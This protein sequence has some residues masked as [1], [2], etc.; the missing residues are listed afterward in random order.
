[1]LGY[2]LRN[3][4]S[5]SIVV[6]SF[7]FRR[8]TH[9]FLFRDNVG[10]VGV[11]TTRFD[12]ALGCGEP[13]V[14]PQVRRYLERRF[15]CQGDDFSSQLAQENFTDALKSILTSSSSWASRRCLA[16]VDEVR[17]CRCKP[18]DLRRLATVSQPGIF[19]GLVRLVAR[20]E[21]PNGSDIHQNREGMAKG[22]DLEICL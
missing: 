12:D 2:F 3:A 8:L 7:G 17:M 16:S 9:V 15:E 22:N 14:L 19:A 6:P 11:I 21:S 4:E 5:L 13:G 10:A 1:M 20:A 18:G